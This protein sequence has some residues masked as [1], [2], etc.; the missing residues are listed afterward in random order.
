MYRN[1]LGQFL[2]PV[3]HDNRELARFTI[4]ITLFAVAIALSTDVAQQ[5]AFFVDWP[6]CLRSWA[7]TVATSLV[8]SVPIAFAFGK[9]HFELYRAKLAADALSRTDALTELPNRRAL[10]EMTESSLP[11]VLALAIFDIDRFKAVNDTYGHLTGD[12]A[13]RSV[14]RMMAQDLGSLGYVARLGGEE[15]AVLASDV[16]TDELTRRLFDF[17]DRLSATPIIIGKLAV[18]VTIS[19]GVALRDQDQTF[20]RL[21]SEA[22]RALY[23]AK[24]AGRNRIQF[25]SPSQLPDALAARVA[26]LKRE[27]IARRA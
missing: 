5:L 3:I 20:D 12:A 22:D 10:I 19:A 1:F 24:A 14:G 21:Y 9:A 6:T 27:A 26:P 8:I 13:I 15:F 11:R 23:Q 16:A 4:R 17:R 18:R 2:S 7:I 25:A